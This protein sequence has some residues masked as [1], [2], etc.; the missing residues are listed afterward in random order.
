V[1]KKLIITVAAFAVVAILVFA[2]GMAA[3]PGEVGAPQAITAATPCPVAACTQPD[4][5]CHAGAEAPQPDGTFEMACPKV[6]G[7][8]NASC[9]A[10]DSLTNHYNK[11]IDASLN[12][13]ILTP[14]VVVVGLVLLV[15]KMK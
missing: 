5:G 4:G 15:L 2:A 3:A 9:H 10:W 14:V 1:F 13:W 6:D 8:T 12:L 11:P 7:C